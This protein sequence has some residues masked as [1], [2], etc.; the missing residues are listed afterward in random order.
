MSINNSLVS[1]FTVWVHEA[2]PKY[3]TEI[4]LKS[5]HSKFVLIWSTPRMRIVMIYLVSKINSPQALWSLC[6]SLKTHVFLITVTPYYTIN[7][8]TSTVDPSSH[9]LT[10]QFISSIWLSVCHVLVLFVCC[11]IKL[12][13]VC[14]SLFPSPSCSLSLFQQWFK[15]G[16]KEEVK[17][18]G[19]AHW[20][21][22]RRKK[23]RMEERRR[24]GEAEEGNEKRKVWRFTCSYV[25]IR[26]GGF[27]FYKVVI[28]PH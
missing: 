13:I 1:C 11:W 26:H 3:W 24:E 10:Q 4:A 17:A 28:M 27:R 21:V 16:L 8:S 14:L 9:T 6:T 5:D 20:T 22:N 15:W 19:A 23:Q 12:F 18:L 25:K 7:T 2:V